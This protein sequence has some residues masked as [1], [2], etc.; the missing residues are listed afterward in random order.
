MGISSKSLGIGMMMV[1]SLLVVAPLSGTA[2]AADEA[3]ITCY[4]CGTGLPGAPTLT[5]KGVVSPQREIFQGI[6]VLTQ[7]VSP[8]INLEVPLT[9]H[10]DP[11]S[12]TVELLFSGG[13]PGGVVKGIL[14]LSGGWGKPGKCQFFW[15][16]N[17]KF[18]NSDG[19]VPAA[20]CK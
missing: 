1:L 6:G 12:K 5:I 15:Y 10:Y 16:A 7:A 13:R 8:P 9:G 17:N 18:G 4:R 19:M 20:P 2:T 14:V 11:N 3:F